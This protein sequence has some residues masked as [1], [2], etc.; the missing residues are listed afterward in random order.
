MASISNKRTAIKYSVKDKVFYG[1]NY[2]YLTFAWIIVLYPLLNVISNSFSDSSFVGAGMVYLFPRG[3][4]LDGYKAIAGNR[5][6]W[7]GYKNT[8][9]YTIAGTSIN[10]VITILC[11]YPLSIKKL[12]LRNLFTFI[13]TFTM[14][15]GGGL[16]PTYLL[17]KSLGMINT[18]WAMIIPGAMGVYNVIIARTFFQSTIP[19][20]LREAAEIDGASDFK[21]LTHVVLSLSA[22]IIAVLA[23]FYAVGHWNTFQ[24]ALYYLNDLDL[25]SLQLMLRN[26]LNNAAL[27]MSQ[28]ETGEIS[29]ER[30][31]EQADF[32]EVVKYCA[33]VVSVI[34]IMAFYPFLQK[35]FVKGIM[36]GSLKG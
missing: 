21:F 6:L 13:L 33:I 29:F 25:F 35:Y 18:R 10:I 15:F 7:I 30:G 24:N 26:L 16:I 17:I 3:I 9:I 4:N 28:M 5:L 34:P 32:V 1:F 27:L 20:E 11:A 31:Q 2:T 14:L 19:D 22:P 36:I 12:P 23:L 8:L